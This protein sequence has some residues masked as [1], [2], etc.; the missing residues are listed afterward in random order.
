M[1]REKKADKPKTKTSQGDAQAEVDSAREETVTEETVAQE[2]QVDAATTNDDVLSSTTFDAFDTDVELGDLAEDTLAD[3]TDAVIPDSVAGP[4]ELDQTKDRL[5][6]TQ[7]E[8]AN[9]RKRA[10]REL[11]DAKRYAN[12]PLM[13]E[14]LPALDNMARAIEAAEKTHDVDSLLEGVK[15]VASQLEDILQRHHCVRIN[16]VDEPFDPHIHEAI[17]QQP[18]ADHAEG[19]VIQETQTGFQL[20]DR[21]VRPSQVIVS[22]AMPE[23]N[24]EDASSEESV[25]PREDDS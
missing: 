2:P 14:L 9:Y 22:T 23:A 24:P 1:A 20:H 12:L 15:M 10:A 19:T 6:R 16:A 7:A 3:A 4:S 8:L 21:V 25:E 11:Q 18:S 13:R 17:L 5:L